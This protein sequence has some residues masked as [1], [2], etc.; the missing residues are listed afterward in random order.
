MRT[1]FADTL[2]WY[3]IANPRDQWH[4]AARN[5]RASLGTVRL[6]TT[7]EVLVEFLSALSGSS[8]FLRHVGVEMIRAILSDST[9]K[10]IPQ[11]HFSFLRGVEFYAQ[12]PD[13]A[14]S[15]VDCISMSVMLEEGITDI[16]TNDHHFTQE[17]FQVL[18][19][20][21]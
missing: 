8:A 16:L 20:R 17:G 9:A 14:Y 18:I 12:R 4:D 7:E 5:A 19:Q 11:S 10:I 15:L 21:P 2:Y 13:K 3:A 6:L 1:V